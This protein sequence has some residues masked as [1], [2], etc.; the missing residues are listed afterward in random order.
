MNCKH[1]YNNFAYVR[2]HFFALCHLLKTVRR[3][4]FNCKRLHKNI[5]FY[6]FSKYNNISLKTLSEDGKASCLIF[7]MFIIYGW[8]AAMSSNCAYFYALCV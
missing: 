5:F 3:D 1:P 2:V 4:A 7:N 6:Y 8:M